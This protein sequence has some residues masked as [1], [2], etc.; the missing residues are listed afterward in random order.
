VSARRLDGKALTERRRARLGDEVSTIRAQAGRGPRLAVVLATQDGAALAYAAAKE[1][2]AKALGIDVDVVRVERPTTAALVE[3]VRAL[4]HDDG[5]DGIL[6]ETPIELGVDLRAVQDAI[7]ADKDIDG[8]STLSLGRLFCGAPGF[9]PATAAAVMALLDDYAVDLLGRRVAVIGRS[10]VVG[11]PLGQLLMARDATVTTCHSRTREL[12]EITR[13][14]DVVCVAIGKP[15]FL[16]GDM[17]KPGSVVVDV[18]TSMVDG[19]LVGDVDFDSVAAVAAAVSPVP[20]GVGPLTTMIV[21]ENVARAA[22][23]R[24][25]GQAGS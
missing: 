23:L 21:L 14:A 9:V 24:L 12:A 22:R 10:L 13:A 1:R 7:P 3:H 17:V 18:G 4:A 2:T 25:L 20:G 15:R 16:T 19:T 11:R 6:V 8:A 5:V